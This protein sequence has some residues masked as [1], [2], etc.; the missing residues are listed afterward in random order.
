MNKREAKR[1][2]CRHAALT[3]ENALE[4]GWESLDRYG[5]DRDK[6][7]DALNDLVTELDRRGGDQ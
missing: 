1:I 7:E 2:A 5:D 4:G 3:I 6:V